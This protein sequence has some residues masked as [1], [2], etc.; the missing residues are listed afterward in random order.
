MTNDFPWVLG[1]LKEGLVRTAY[2]VGDQVRAPVL[3]ARAPADPLF[4]VPAFERGC[5]HSPVADAE[6]PGVPDGLAD[7]GPGS[8]DSGGCP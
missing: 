1:G 3:D 4:A 2:V 7:L 5:Q 6:V 8:Q